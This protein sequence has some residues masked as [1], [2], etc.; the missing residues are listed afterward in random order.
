MRKLVKMLISLALCAVMLFSYASCEYISCVINGDENNNSSDVDVKSDNDNKEISTSN[1][2]KDR[3]VP[4]GYT[5]GVEYDLCFHEEYAVY[6][7]ETYEEVLEAVEL[8]KSNGSTIKRSIAF[9][10][11][12]ELLDVKFCFLYSRSKAQK[13]EEGKN[14][15]DRKIDDG[16]FK[17]FGL[18]EDVT[19][20]EL[21]YSTVSRYDSLNISYVKDQAI[22]RDFMD[23]YD[24]DKITFDWYLS[25]F[26]L[27][28][29]GLYYIRLNGE[30][31]V[32]VNYEETPLPSE[33]YQKF[34][35]SIVIIE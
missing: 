5:G 17:W 29:D 10:C 4:V 3:I 13:L 21:L 27:E 28:P 18:F 12:G 15:F 1:N 14:F 33:Y 19:I 24:T 20:D 7:L 30:I 11:E 35:D 34:A 6:W 9:D 22:Y 25:E 26:G 8:L 32:K 2:K 31:Y 23:I 16:E